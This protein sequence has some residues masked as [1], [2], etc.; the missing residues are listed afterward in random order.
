[1]QSIHDL[2]SAYGA[3]HQ[4]P[5]NKRV[6]WVCVPAIVFSLL[7]LLGLL[8]LLPVPAGLPSW[9]NWAGMVIALAMVY[10]FVLA[11]RLALGMILV[12]VLNVAALV[13]LERAQLPLGYAF[14]AT[15]VGAWIGQFVGHKFEGASPSFF[16]DVQFLLIGPL[17]LLA[18][19]Y[20]RCGWSY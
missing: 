5:V 19:L 20:R 1:M 13:A 3:S 17:W 12:V 18:Y 10:Y 9:L 15:F 8:W 4:N 14:A 11:P 7:G 16:Q 6:H 2:L